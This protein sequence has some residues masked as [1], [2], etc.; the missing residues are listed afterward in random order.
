MN[1]EKCGNE[2]IG[3]IME[4]TLDKLEGKTRKSHKC[5]NCDNKVNP[6][7][8]YNEYTKSHPGEKN[9]LI[10]IVNKSKEIKMEAK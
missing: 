3:S 10:R 5:L 2:I 7:A 9:F 8:A 1:C 4:V 6:V